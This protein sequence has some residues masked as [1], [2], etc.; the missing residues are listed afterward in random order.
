VAFSEC[1]RLTN[2]G[3]T[4]LA[5]LPRLRELRL[6]GM[7]KVTQD[8]VAAFPSGVRVQYSL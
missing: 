6:S 1:H 3:I 7:A 8:V 4:T 2:A 5:R